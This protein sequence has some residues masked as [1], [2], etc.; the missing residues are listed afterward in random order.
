MTTG[1]A[2]SSLLLRHEIHLH[3]PVSEAQPLFHQEGLRRSVNVMTHP[4]IPALVP[5]HME[6][7]KILFT[8]PKAGTPLGLLSIQKIGIVTEKAEFKV[9]C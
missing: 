7:V 8:I 2:R 3:L 9:F 5:V 6:P 4:A 1:Q